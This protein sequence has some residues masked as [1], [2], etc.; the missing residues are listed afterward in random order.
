ML[1]LFVN[2]KFNLGERINGKFEHDKE[3]DKDHLET[4]HSLLKSIMATAN[5]KQYTELLF[6]Q[7]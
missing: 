4:L 7:N 5:Y 6:Y 2:V 3:H 1:I